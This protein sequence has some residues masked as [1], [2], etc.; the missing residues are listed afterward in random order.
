[1]RRKIL[2]PTLLAA[3]LLVIG[4]TAEQLAS[5]RGVRK[6]VADVRTATTQSIDELQIAIADLPPEDP[7]R[8]SLE[9]KVARL[10]E[11]LAKADKWL[12]LADAMIKAA[13]DGDLSDPGLRNAVGA[14][15]YGAIALAVIGFGTALLENRKKRQ[16]YDAG[17]QIVKSVEAVMPVKTDEQKLAMNAVQDESTRKIVAEMKAA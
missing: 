2:L 13:E 6:E 3:G 12:P 9:G 8:V 15:P 4:C 1:M 10:K 14:L 17:K 11:N 16:M 7:V 5:L